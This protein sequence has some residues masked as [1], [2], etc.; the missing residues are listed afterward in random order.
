MQFIILLVTACGVAAQSKK[1]MKD[2]FL[3]ACRVCEQVVNWPPKW[4]DRATVGRCKKHLAGCQ[5]LLNRYDGLAAS[6]QLH[7]LPQNSNTVEHSNEKVQT[8]TRVLTVALLIL[9][10]VLLASKF[11]AIKTCWLNGWVRRKSKYEMVI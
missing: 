4:V 10:F 9:S 8:V 2:D 5:G 11:S 7:I 3:K 1:E 6:G